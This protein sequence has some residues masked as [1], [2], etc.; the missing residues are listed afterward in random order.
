MNDEN[1]NQDNIVIDCE[2]KE[3]LVD[4]RTKDEIFMNER[5]NSKKFKVLSKEAQINL[6]KDFIDDNTDFEFRN[7]AELKQFIQVKLKHDVFVNVI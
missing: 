5:L 3:V 1:I 7:A 4:G 2:S 6:V